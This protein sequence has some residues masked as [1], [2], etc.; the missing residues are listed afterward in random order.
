[1]DKSNEGEIANTIVNKARKT[2]VKGLVTGLDFWLA[3]ILIKLFQNINEY[4][5]WII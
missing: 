5:I 4:Y 1:M 3:L 2:I